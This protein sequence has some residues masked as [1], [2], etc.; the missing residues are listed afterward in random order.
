MSQIEQQR[1]EIKK[2]RKTV[3]GIFSTILIILFL[4]IT[5]PPIVQLYDRNDIWVGPVPLS[6][7][8][9]F[10]IPFLAAITMAVLYFFDKKFTEE[11]EKLKGGHE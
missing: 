3:Y 2:K 10:I 8:C 4:M 7:F 11:L 6:Q 9:I 5:A 1:A